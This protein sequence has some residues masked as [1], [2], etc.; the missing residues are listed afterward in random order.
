MKSK[1]EMNVTHSLKEHYKMLF[2]QHVLIIGNAVLIS[3]IDHISNLKKLYDN[4]KKQWSIPLNN[5][6]SFKSQV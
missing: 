4:I 1:A 6:I 3:I 5:I 2:W